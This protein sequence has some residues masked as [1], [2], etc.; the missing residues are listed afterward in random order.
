MFLSNHIRAITSPDGGK[1]ESESVP[2]ASPVI[3]ARYTGQP[4]GQ[5]TWPKAPWEQVESTSTRQAG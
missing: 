5:P 3:Q 4:T 1:D 2:E